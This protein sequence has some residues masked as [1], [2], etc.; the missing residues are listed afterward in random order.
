MDYLLR[1]LELADR[2]LGRTS[3]N[4]AVGAVIVKDSMIVGEGYTQP[5][6]S[7]HAEVVALQAAGRRAD[8][9][10]LYVTLE[11]CC[12]HGRTPP[13]TEA[14][15]AAGIRTVHLAMLDPFPLVNGQ[16]VEALR[17]AGLEVDV[18]EHA[19]AAE[20]LNQAFVHFVRTERPFVTVKWAMT[21]DGK[22]ATRSGDA[23]WISGEDS[24]QLA[25]RER[26]ASDAIVVGVGTVLADDPRLTVR[27]DPRDDVRAHR[28]RP[29]I[30]VVLD[31][32]ART[33]PTSQ[34]LADASE[35]AVLIATTT[36]AP[37]T[38]VDRLAQAGADVVVLPA[39]DGRVD[40]RAVLAELARRGAIR[41]L[42]EGGAQV[43]AAF[44]RDRL[45]DRILAFVA[46]KLVGGSAA[47]TP[48]GGD[49]VET[50]AAAIVLGDLS[51]RSVGSDLLVEGRVTYEEPE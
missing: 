50:M 38:G 34:L 39:R 3:P 33:P 28:A 46:P 30:R 47:P 35:G 7:A 36:R 44:V 8:G 18:G 19:A 22:I 9:A 2:A 14:I 11:P 6:G 5:P 45:A 12:H 13:C 25:H 37:A 1:A 26:D 51:W 32:Q 43:N 49:G 42:V 21:L 48:L 20:C 16:G 31:S 23:R 15:V 4:P 40:L 29:P 41:V 17:Q 10:D 24:R 27:L